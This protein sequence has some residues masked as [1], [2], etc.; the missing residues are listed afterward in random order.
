MSNDT[1]IK[2]TL[3]IATYEKD[4]A[5]IIEGITKI[6]ADS[7]F[8]IIESKNEFLDRQE[9]IFKKGSH[10]WFTSFVIEQKRSGAH[11]ISEIQYLEP[12][13]FD[14]LITKSRESIHSLTNRTRGGSLWSSFWML[15]WLALGFAF[16]FMLMYYIMSFFFLTSESLLVAIGLTICILF[17]VYLINYLYVQRIKKTEAQFTDEFIQK[18]KSSLNIISKQNVENKI[19]CWSCFKEIQPHSDYCSECGVKLSHSNL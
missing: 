7:S 1:R 5:T 19:Y 13:S 4:L 15:R 17:L 8:K 3:E 18:L 14:R 9:I 10:K 6:L 12:F 11:I 16:V 2:R